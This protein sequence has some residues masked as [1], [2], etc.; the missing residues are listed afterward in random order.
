MCEIFHDGLGTNVNEEGIGY[1]NNLINAL[2][3]K[4]IDLEVY[5]TLYHWD[6]L[7]HLEETMLGYLN[8]D[9]TEQLQQFYL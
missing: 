8:K 9:I 4:D 2:L 6:L 7:L 5:V 1:Y 3:H